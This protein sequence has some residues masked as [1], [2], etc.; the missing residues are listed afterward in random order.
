MASIEKI[1]AEQVKKG[2]RL[3]V[4]TMG[5]IRKQTVKFSRGISSINEASINGESVPREKTVGN[6]VV[7]GSTIQR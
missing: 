3:Q 1:A 4:F 5:Q 6:E 2:D 7:L